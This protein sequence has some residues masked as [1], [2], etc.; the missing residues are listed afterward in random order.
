MSALIRAQ[1]SRETAIAEGGSGRSP[2]VSS[3]FPASEMRPAEWVFVLQS[4]SEITL[5]TGLEVRARAG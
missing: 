4:V 1:A 3:I 5:L 2:G